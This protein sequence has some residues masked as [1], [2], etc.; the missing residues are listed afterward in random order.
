MRS[1]RKLPREEIDKYENTRLD[2]EKMIEH[3][4]RINVERELEARL[5]RTQAMNFT[6]NL[7]IDE[8]QKKDIFVIQSQVFAKTEEECP[9]YVPAEISLARFSLCDGIKEVYHAFPRPGTV[10]LGYKWACLQNSAKTHKIPLEFFSEAEVDTAGSEHGKYTEDGEILDQM[11]NI[12]DG[13]N[14]LFTLPEFE[15]EI[16][17]VLETLKKKSGRELSSLNI[18]SL[19]LLLFELANKPGSE[20]HDQES[21][22]PFESVAERELE[23]EKFLYCPDMNCSWHEETTDTRHC[24]SARVRSWIYT[25]L[26][27]CCHRYN[28]DLLPLQH[29]PPLQALPC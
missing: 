4:K 15:K 11:M 28:I 6:R 17:G 2:H 21:F 22:L 19:P 1:W 26:D 29:Y 27:V 5:K 18:L 16:T 7:S 24:S 12:L 25:L 9:K 14:F 3:F 8:I 10:P 20:A 23:K 13:E